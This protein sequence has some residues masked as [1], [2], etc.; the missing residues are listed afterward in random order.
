MSDDIFE[1]ECTCGHV[2]KW[3]MGGACHSG[4]RPCA[5]G[6]KSFEDR[7]LDKLPPKRQVAIARDQHMWLNGFSCINP[8]PE[9]CQQVG[10]ELI[11]IV[12]ASEYRDGLGISKLTILTVNRS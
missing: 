11:R 4:V 7:R 5:K 1:A 2:G 8:T 6:C 12:E 10:R 3:H 9:F